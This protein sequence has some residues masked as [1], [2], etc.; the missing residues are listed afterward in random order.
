[1]LEV[2]IAKTLG[3][4]AIASS[5]LLG[6]CLGKKKTNT[7]QSQTGPAANDSVAPDKVLYQRS[8]DDMSKGHY[9]WPGFPCKP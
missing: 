4:A 5:L 9:R 2:R 7:Q 1:V 8:V 6:G 3:V